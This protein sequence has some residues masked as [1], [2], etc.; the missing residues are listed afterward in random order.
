MTND[1]GT[2]LSR[3]DRESFRTKDGS[4]VLEIVHPSFSAARVQSVAEARVPAGGETIAH[5]HHRSEE[6]YVFTAGAGSMELGG[7]MFD[8]VA[9]DSVVIPP[10]TPHKLWA[11]A[12]DLVL[13]CV[14]SPAYSHEDTV[15]LDQ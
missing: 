15:L 9:G 8:V 13:L 14:C 5:L 6:I 7:R 4:S 2:V 3:S 10:G 12:E 11:G 1:D